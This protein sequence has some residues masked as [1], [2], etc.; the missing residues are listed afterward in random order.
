M[1]YWRDEDADAAVVVQIP[2]GGVLGCSGA[3]ER[4]DWLNVAG[5]VKSGAKR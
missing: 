2:I 1:V 3:L 5:G 4:H